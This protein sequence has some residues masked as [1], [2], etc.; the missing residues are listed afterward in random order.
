MPYP[1]HHHL[2]LDC[3]CPL[4]FSASLAITLF[5]LSSLPLLPLP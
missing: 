5:L 2:R 4:L 3:S 1:Y